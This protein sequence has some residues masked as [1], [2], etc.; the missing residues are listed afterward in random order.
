MQLTR[1]TSLLFLLNLIDAIL[2]VY[3]VQNGF[4]T[5]GNH[6]MANLLDIG[7]IPFL[8]VKIAAGGVT[9][10]VLSYGGHYKLARYG[11]VIALTAYIA[12]MLVH[13]M[14]GLTVAGIV[15]VRHLDQISTC[16]KAIFAFVI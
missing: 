12:L 14:T 4:A 11:V 16:S 9:A 13:L 2:T 3:W 8:T 5:E 1:Q 15:T 7:A 10:F 6:L